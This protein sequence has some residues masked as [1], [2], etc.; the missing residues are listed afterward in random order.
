MNS[1]KALRL[2]V[3]TSMVLRLSM[4][5]YMTTLEY[6]ASRSCC[7]PEA[8]SLCAPLSASTMEPRSAAS[9]SIVSG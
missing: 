2:L 1:L 5:S 4:R 6:T 7:A 8:A 3:L 9:A